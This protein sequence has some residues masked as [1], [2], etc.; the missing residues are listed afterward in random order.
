MFGLN[1]GFDNTP[2][3]YGT[4]ETMFHTIPQVEKKIKNDMTP[5]NLFVLDEALL[6]KPFETAKGQAARIISTDIKVKG[7]DALGVAIMTDENEKTETLHIYT[8]NGECYDAWA[9]NK[10]GLRL[11]MK[12]TIVRKWFCLYHHYNKPGDKHY[13][14]EHYGPF[15]TKEEAENYGIKSINYVK[16]AVYPVE[17]EE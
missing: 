17:Y 9:V 10:E 4:P 1:D 3:M 2:L 16:K 5:N 6:G 11:V 7:F 15:E 8:K 12:H 14:V 13:N